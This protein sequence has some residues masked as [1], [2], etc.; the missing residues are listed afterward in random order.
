MLGSGIV[1]ERARA[2]AYPRVQRDWDS[3]RQERLCYCLAHGA[4]GAC[5][6]INTLGSGASSPSTQEVRH[7]PCA[8]AGWWKAGDASKRV[9]NSVLAGSWGRVAVSVRKPKSVG[10]GRASARGCCL[11]VPRL[12]QRVRGRPGACAEQGPPPRSAQAEGA[13]PLR[14]LAVL[15]ASRWRERLGKNRLS[16]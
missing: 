4:V 12:G 10:Q 2:R 13:G 14:L 7:R 9:A 1:R 6:F 5:S 3:S 8:C 15:P 11:W 16:F